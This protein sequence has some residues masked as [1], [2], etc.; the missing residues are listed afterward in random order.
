MYSRQLSGAEAKQNY[1]ARLPNS[2]P[3]AFDCAVAV[4]EDGEDIAGGQLVATAYL[5]ALQP[6]LLVTV[7][8]G[9]V[10]AD[11]ELQRARCRD[12]THTQKRRALA[13][14]GSLTRPFASR[15]NVS[16]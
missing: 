4:Y 12:I 1:A 7:A 5:S 8:L 3:Y 16:L 10:D 6:E 15:K 11:D 14:Q 2:P 9:I 13:K